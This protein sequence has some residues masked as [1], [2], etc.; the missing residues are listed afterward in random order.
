MSNFKKVTR[1]EGFSKDL[2][3]LLKKYRSL[4]EDLEVFVKAQLGSVTSF[5]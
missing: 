4:E 5:L 1:G 3:Q 2:K